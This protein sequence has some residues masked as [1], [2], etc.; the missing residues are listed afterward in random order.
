MFNCKAKVKLF[1]VVDCSC[2]SEVRGQVSCD[3]FV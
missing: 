3:V 1:Y 2:A